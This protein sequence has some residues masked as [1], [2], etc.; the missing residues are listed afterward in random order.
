MIK[1]KSSTQEYTFTLSKFPDGTSQAWLITPEPEKHQDM[2][3]QW[4]FE[5]EGELFHVLQLGYL[6]SCQYSIF[7][8]LDCPYLPYGRQDKMI[9][10]QTTFARLVFIESV[11]NAGYQ[12]IKTYDA[13]SLTHPFIVSKEPLELL[14]AALPGHDVVVFP[15]QGALKRYNHL[16]PENM[17]YLS[18]H[19]KRNQIT[20]EIEGLELDVPEEYL[21]GK[22]VLVFD[23]LCDGGRTFIEVAKVLKEN[24]TNSLTLAVS[25]GIF[26][27]GL[28]LIANA[29][30]SKVYTTNSL[31]KWQN[32]DD[33]FLSDLKEFMFYKFELKIIGVVK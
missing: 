5:N 25:H 10:N 29:G 23:D 7:P 26:S 22:N 24:S 11:I 8:V 3:V 27:K 2:T 15:D 13:H 30:Y 9:S 32:K 1:L 21:K 16:L 31:I 18:C 17:D 14:E 33:K 19:K 12:C 28:D 6:L 4:M 20:G